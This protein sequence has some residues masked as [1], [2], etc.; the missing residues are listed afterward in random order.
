MIPDTLAA[1]RAIAQALLIGF[2]VGAQREASLGERHPGMRDF[3]LISL[4][5]AI[6]GLLRLPWLAAT[7]LASITVLLAVFHFQ[8]TERS[9][10][11]T[12]MAAVAT[13]CF[14]YL[15]TTPYATLAVGMAIV[16][17]AFLEAKK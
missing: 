8:V 12:E 14:G 13:F 6:C 3:L 17:V 9:G 11:T 1:V 10:I 2:L 7:A 5:G 4:V 15:T 16:V